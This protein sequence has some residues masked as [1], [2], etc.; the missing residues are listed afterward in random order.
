MALPSIAAGSYAAAQKLVDTS[1]SGASGSGFADLVKQSL[2]S[3]DGQAKAVDHQIAAAV[4]G[5][6]DYVSVA[7]SVAESETAI[8]TLVAVRDKVLAAYDEIMRMT[9]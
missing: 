7:T 9:V 1:G 5:H 2:A 6:A 8:E 4:A 3:F